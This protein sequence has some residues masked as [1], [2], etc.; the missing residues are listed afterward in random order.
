MPVSDEA[1]LQ[2]G[3]AGGTSSGSLSS[4][5][6]PAG[7]GCNST[8]SSSILATVKEQELQFERLTRELEVE[9]LM[10]ANQLERCKL[11]G[12]ETAS[13]GSI[14]SNE[15]S[16]SW[17]KTDGAPKD[18]SEDE[19][20]E[21][22]G[23]ELV[24]S[25]LRALQQQPLF[26]RRDS[27]AIDV[28][29]RGPAS[30]SPDSCFQELGSTRSRPVITQPD[31]NMYGAA[32]ISC[33]TTPQMYEMD[34]QTNPSLSQK[35][36]LDNTFSCL[37]SNMAHETAFIKAT[38]M[39]LVSQTGTPLPSLS[40]RAGIRPMVTS[41][42]GGSPPSDASFSQNNPMTSTCN[43]IN[44]SNNSHCYCLSSNSSKPNI[45][46]GIRPVPPPH[47]ACPPH[48]TFSPGSRTSKTFQRT[49]VVA[50]PPNYPG[51]ISQENQPS[52]QSPEKHQLEQPPVQ[53]PGSLAVLQDYANQPPPH[54][55]SF[56][57][58]C[59]PSTERS[60]TPVHEV[61]VC[62][63]SRTS[64]PQ[65]HPRCF[66]LHNAAVGNGTWY[67]GQQT[68][69]SAEFPRS[70][71][72]GEPIRLLH[73]CTSKQ[74]ANSNNSVLGMHPG[75]SAQDGS[76]ETASQDPSLTEVIQ[77][78]QQPMPSIQANAAAYLQH[79]C[80]RDGRVKAEVRRLGGLAVLSNL[81]EHER[82]EVQRGACGA[83]KNLV[84]GSDDNKR[85][86]RSAG[87]VPALAFLLRHTR[88]LELVESATGV[89]WNLS[90]CDP[91]KM[92]IVHECLGAITD[93]VIVPLSHQVWHRR[94]GKQPHDQ[95][96]KILCNATGFLRNISSAGEEARRKMRECDG[97]VEAL[98]QITRSTIGSQD[99]SSKVVENAVCVLRNL[100]YRLAQ[101]AGQGPERTRFDENEHQ[102]LLGAPPRLQGRG[103]GCWAKKRK[104]LQDD[105][106][107][108]L[109]GPTACLDGPAGCAALLWHPSVVPLYLGL[110][111]ECSNPVTLEG[112]AGA[113][114]NLAASDWKWSA[115]V[116][117]SV[118]REKGL[119]VLV[120]LLRVDSERVVCAIATALRNMARD[121]RNKDLIGKYAMRDLVERLPEAGMAGQMAYNDSTLTAV[122]CALHEVT[123]SNMENAKALRDAG[124]IERLVALARGKSDGVAA[125]VVRAAIQVLSSLWLYRDLRTLYKKDGWTQQ[126]FTGTASAMDRP[127]FP[128]RISVQAMCPS[129]TAP[130]LSSTSA[131]SM[132]P[133]AIDPSNSAEGGTVLAIMASPL[134][135][136]P[137]A[138]LDVTQVSSTGGDCR[139]WA[140]DATSMA[141]SLHPPYPV[142]SLPNASY[143]KLL[144]LPG[145][146]N[147]PG[148]RDWNTHRPSVTSQVNVGDTCG[149]FQPSQQI[150]TNGKYSGLYATQSGKY[151]NYS[152]LRC[153]DSVDSWV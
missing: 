81:L 49:S 54:R 75:R 14:S 53:R 112:S 134:Q 6:L 46:R 133:S 126:H 17:R 8:E 36:D 151:S 51:I 100:S 144:P 13:L 110:L 22:V 31:G 56:P 65:A 5:E 130:L 91:L 76:R 64:S 109:V 101:E 92:P 55:P 4:F 70:L 27:Q 25:C 148:S 125:K 104:V 113:L 142:Q 147:L 24:D 103:A 131:S 139:P 98:L 137:L 10:V 33:G 1:W 58:H 132:V 40:D 119:P 7:D 19:G 37:H 127:R 107:G 28:M 93:F 45:Q 9:R 62:P 18:V 38:P 114:Q 43:N 47:Q 41:F 146:V 77:M 34:M 129:H 72:Y 97:L 83:L 73:R 78:L 59:R 124:G 48:K 111:K 88:D 3:H 150:S 68:S 79:V 35:D 52:C 102:G 2:H 85:A 140:T 95:A 21:S 84:F 16:F 44:G 149:R 61:P 141:I 23:S 96:S 116:R 82:L 143:Q 86:L 117:A 71:T 106:D 11:Q 145:Q 15:E 69:S 26:E 128:S 115:C 29:V 67:S 94:S 20:R 153:Q 63:T 80:Y 87:G 12:A 66:G 60:L 30:F 39:T 135:A 50:S 136:E 138:E 105:S 120:E 32:M 123:T 122:C 121:A 118:R 99:V 89:L 108:E 74:L 90:S 152:A 42:C 57:L